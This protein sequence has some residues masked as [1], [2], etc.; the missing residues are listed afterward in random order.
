M[1]TCR[2]PLSIYKVTVYDC[3]LLTAVYKWNHW[4]GASCCER[5]LEG[6]RMSSSSRKVCFHLFAKPANIQF[7]SIN[8][9]ISSPLWY[10]SAL[11]LCLTV[12]RYLEDWDFL[13]NIW[14][15]ALHVNTPSID[16]QWLNNLCTIELLCDWNIN[17]LAWIK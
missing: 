11:H 9:D 3:S 14:H 1:S 5:L 13:L 12:T 8:Y 4:A 2:I 7:N 16:L 15:A 17:V 10:L 6:S